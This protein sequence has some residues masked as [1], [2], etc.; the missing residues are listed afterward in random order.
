VLIEE[1]TMK[2][3]IFVSIIAVVLLTACGSYRSANR[4]LSN[5]SQ[6]FTG[7]PAESFGGG[8]APEAPA[9]EPSAAQGAGQQSV[10]IER[11]VIQNAE[12][13]IVVADVDAHMKSVEALAVEMGGYVVSSNRYQTQTGNG[14]S[15]PVGQAVIRVPSER[16]DEALDKIKSDVVEIQSENRSGQDVTAEYV[17]LQS[18]LKNLEAT[19]AQ[20]VKIMDSTTRA[21]DTLNVF[22]QLTSIREQ[23]EL[24]KGQ[25]KYYEESAALSAVTV[26]ILAEE[27]LQPIE[28][29]GWKPSGVVRDS[30]QSLIYFFQ[31][32]VDF[33]IRF[34]LLILPAL[35]LIAVPV[36]LVFLGVRAILRR[37]R[38]PKAR[39]QAQPEEPAP[40]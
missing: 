7:L 34:L 37:F 1:K 4:S 30:I 36:Y 8:A 26:H 15:V 28:I 9:P 23:I 25:M 14:K 11:L 2:R 19:E 21:E 31:D 27:T 12:L 3:L 22:N 32:F 35:V 40:K 33:M 17:D 38:R 10:G 24:V 13:T 29:A 5:D 6:K 39:R 20:L 18:R 16:L